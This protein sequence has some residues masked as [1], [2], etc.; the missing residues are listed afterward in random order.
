MMQ[1][2][3]SFTSITENVENLNLSKPSAQAIIHKLQDMHLQT[4]KS[5]PT[6]VYV[7]YYLPCDRASAA[8]PHAPP[9]LSAPH[10]CLYTQLSSYGRSGLTENGR[11]TFLLF[12]KSLNPT[13]ILISRLHTD[14]SFSLLTHIRLSASLD[15]ELLFTRNTIAKPPSAITS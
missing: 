12:K 2:G 7:S 3:H 9:S 6:V 14:R 11:I 8:A 13:T 1:P 10:C 5:E 4:R 15:P